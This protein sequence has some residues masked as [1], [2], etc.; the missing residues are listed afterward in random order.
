MRQV[1]QKPESKTIEPGC[2]DHIT[3]VSVFFPTCYCFLK[4]VL[5]LENPLRQ[6]QAFED[7]LIAYCLFA[8]LPLSSLLSP[9]HFGQL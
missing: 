7:P 5:E 2:G 9:R 6:L 8:K 4:C 3:I 1:D